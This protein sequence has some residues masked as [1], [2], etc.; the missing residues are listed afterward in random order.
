SAGQIGADP[1]PFGQQLTATVLIKGQLT[2]I[3]EFE[4]IVLRA[5]P[6]GST[7]RL[8]DV[9]TL[10]MGSD[11]YMFGSTLNGQPSAALGVQLSTTGNAMNT[12]ALV[13]DKMEELSQFFPDG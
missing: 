5:N 7:V 2:E 9:A 3:E 8:K 10:E 13:R 12:S 4:Q 6:D 11:A 1:N